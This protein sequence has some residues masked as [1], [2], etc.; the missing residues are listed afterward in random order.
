M[1][2]KMFGDVAKAVKMY[3]ERGKTDIMSLWL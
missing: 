3:Q 2:G 1:L